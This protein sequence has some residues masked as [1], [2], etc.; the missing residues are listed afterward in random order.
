M[1]KIFLLIINQY[2]AYHAYEPEP[3]ITHAYVPELA[4]T[5]NWAQHRFNTWERR[6]EDFQRTLHV[7]LNVAE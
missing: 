5:F 2:K 1:K 3:S 6:N 7:C 4:R